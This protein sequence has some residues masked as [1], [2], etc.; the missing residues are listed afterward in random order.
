MIRQSTKNLQKRRI[1]CPSKCEGRILIVL[2]NA[3]PLNHLFVTLRHEELVLGGS[4]SH[5][6]RIRLCTL[7]MIHEWV[8]SQQT[9]RSRNCPS[10]C[11]KTQSNLDSSIT[12]RRPRSKLWRRQ[13]FKSGTKEIF[14]SP[15]LLSSI[16]FIS[17]IFPEDVPP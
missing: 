3:R 11:D 15:L 2:I 12:S 1:Y 13:G 9:K 7:M 14:I 6:K 4:Q 16:P 5:G 8:Q 10:W 17:F